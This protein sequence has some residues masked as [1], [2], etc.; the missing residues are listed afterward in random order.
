MSDATPVTR[1]ALIAR[2][3]DRLARAGVPEPERDAR[4]LCRW[5]TGLNGAALAAALDALV[6]PDEA[7]R[8]DAAIAAREAR[9][10]VGQITG[11]RE[12]WGR[13][14]EV[15]AEV[16]DP[17]PETECLIA[18]ALEGSA[19]ARLLDLGT[20]S[21]C[22]L[23]TLLAEW[24]AAWGTGVDLSPA[25]LAVAAR[26]AARHGVAKRAEFAAGDWY[27]GAGGRYD[28]IVANPPY[29]A[30]AELAGLAPEVRDHEPHIALTPGGD[31]LDAYRA[32]AAGL[33]RHL[34]PGGRLLLEIG[35]T[36]AEAVAG[37]L[38]QAGGTVTGLGLDLD[39]RNRV[40]SA[41]IC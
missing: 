40:I 8:F 5:A 33:R 24:P 9:K 6:G 22:I 7:A 25:A 38:E 26:N 14:F 36:Q 1:A 3:A 15:T 23:V 4:R 13:G 20:G 19:A 27:S 18:H 10:P 41:R 34:E 28:L 37:I 17:R 2:A 39:G 31:G 11:F 35:P 21:G 12:F 30:E 32:I 29:I 16:L